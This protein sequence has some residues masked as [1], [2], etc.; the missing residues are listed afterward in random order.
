M[1]EVELQIAVAYP[2]SYLKKRARNETTAFVRELVPLRIPRFL[3]TEAPCILLAQTQKSLETQRENS[4]SIEIERRLVGGRLMAPAKAQHREAAITID[5]ARDRLAVGD[6][7]NATCYR[8]R[9]E[10]YNPATYRGPFNDHTPLDAETVTHSGREASIA[11]L[12]ATV[13]GWAFIGDRLYLPETPPSFQVR[14]WRLVDIEIVNGLNQTYEDS[15]SHRGFHFSFLHHEQALKGA[16]LAFQTVSKTRDSDDRTFEILN[17]DA[18][19]W[20][21]HPFPEATVNAKAAAS[22]FLFG[23]GDSLGLMASEGVETLGLIS[24]LRDR[25]NAGDETAGME[26]ASTLARLREAEFFVSKKHTSSRAI[27]RKLSTFIEGMIE[28]TEKPELT[29]TPAAVDDCLD[30]L[31]GF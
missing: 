17:I 23:L 6:F 15:I 16:E 1:D 19:A 2:V 26:I 3:F 12:A 22:F 8:C 18:T 29:P 14:P 4:P 5:V 20:V 24:R 27:L 25:A 13:G 21:K 9:G 7:V 30:A 31:L 11:R 10:I 28:L